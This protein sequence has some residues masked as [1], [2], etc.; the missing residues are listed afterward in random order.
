MNIS[1]LVF[2]EGGRDKK[3]LMN[4]FDLPQFEF[5]TKNWFFTFDNASGS[6]PDIILS[7]CHNVI[8]GRCYDL[9]LCFI[10]LDKLKS[11]YGDGWE[12]E[13]KK[14]EVKYSNITIIWQIPNAEGEYK[15]VLGDKPYGKHKL[16]QKAKEKI[17]KFIN[18]DF[19]ERILKP[20]RNKEQ[21]LK[22]SL[23]DEKDGLWV[24]FKEK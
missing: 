5:R 12:E 18:S 16:N 8:S 11:D 10:D 19:W 3:F 17:E 23:G 6:S 9:V 4:L 22:Q 2:S 14:L 21:E 7:Q 1:C 15:K 24:W 13:Q 20:I